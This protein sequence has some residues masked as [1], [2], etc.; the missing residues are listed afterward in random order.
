MTSRRDLFG[1]Q[2]ALL[3]AVTTAMAMAERVWV[4][5]ALVV[6]AVFVAGVFRRRGRPGWC[7]ERAA[8]MAI[9]AAFVFM[10]FDWLWISTIGV[11]ALSHFMILVCA[12][13]LCSHQTVRDQSLVFVLLLI[14]LM[15][16]SLVS[17]H[18]L[19]VLVLG[20]YLVVGLHGL[21]RLHLSVEAARAERRN[22]RAFGRLSGRSGG[23]VPVP[24]RHLAGVSGLVGGV[25]LVV[26]LLVFIVFPRVGG[27]MWGRLEG[28]IAAAAGSTAS[29]AMDFRRVGPIHPST[30]KVFR[31]Q[32]LAADGRVLGPDQVEPYFRRAVFDQYHRRSGPMGGVW[33]WWKVTRDH[34]DPRQV[35]LTA[36]EELDG[37][38]PV[39]PAAYGLSDCGLI[40]QRYWLEP[41]LHRFLLA[42]YPP[43]EV[44]VP[45]VR[46]V[47]KSLDDLTLQVYLPVRQPLRYEVVSVARITPQLAAAMASER[48]PD[49]EPPL[50]LPD[51]PLPR[52]AEIR[53]LVARIDAQAGTTG[54][55]DGPE[56]RERFARAAVAF[57]QSPPFTYTLNSPPVTS[58]REPI[59]DFLLDNHAGHCQYFAAALTLL[60]QYRGIPARLVSGYLGHDYNEV[61]GYYTVTREDA[62]AWVE[63]F[64]PGRD[65]VRFDPT[66]LTNA[67]RSSRA[68]WWIALYRYMDYLQFQ[69][70][71]LVIDYDADA[72]HALF[73]RLVAWL[74]R[75]VG[76]RATLWGAVG[77]FLS[78]LIWWRSGLS[79][80]DRVLYGLFT[81]MVVTLVVLV[82]YVVIVVAYRIAVRVY[83]WCVRK[84]PVRL[85]GDWVFY[86]RFRR[87]MAELGWML[88]PGQTPAE[89]AAELASRYPVLQPTRELVAVYY[90]ARYGGRPVSP[91][92]RRRI[93]LFLRRLS[94]LRRADLEAGSMLDQ[95]AD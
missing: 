21:V 85:V 34:S 33:E 1:S 2:A 66:P 53:K 84:I 27:G 4:Y 15:V 51:P 92:Q 72:R 44:Y 65:W 68:H 19:F 38:I 13:K 90:A 56:T 67:G 37:A 12:V 71:N 81:V 64:I 73:A 6:V 57:L 59:G 45:E 78:E 10:L 86:E 49:D 40:T 25:A 94:T 35:V 20:M 60:C 61:G 48:G 50:F 29:V 88:A 26:G 87:R 62:H 83:R 89:F 39:L 77:A 7:N 28:H 36:S 24:G 31:A 76:E 14:L 55:P 47:R 82:S 11:V 5:A 43:R 17:G 30:R 32:L 63:V 3:L 95:P 23:P 91:V 8:K 46:R 80:F 93:E 22:A 18:F 52:E 58:D 42:L 69:W 79:W 9:L 74:R 41:A 70:S 16:A 54:L 75:P